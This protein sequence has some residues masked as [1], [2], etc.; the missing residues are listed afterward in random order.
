MDYQIEIVE[1]TQLDTAVVR[2]HVA[3][4]GVGEFLGRAFGEVLGA[5]GAAD[6]AGPPF[7]RYVMTDEGWEI[8]GGF[9]VHARV[10]GSGRVEP[11]SLPGG[12]VASTVHVG[13]YMELGQA[14][15]AIEAWLAKNGY[16]ATGAPWEAYLD[17]PTVDAPR[18]LVVSPCTRA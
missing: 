7:A 18:T 11:S 16:L 4:D 13:S 15:A 14:Y 9:P 10:A 1:V 5:V 3:H 6:I 12:M 8:E 2:E 17:E